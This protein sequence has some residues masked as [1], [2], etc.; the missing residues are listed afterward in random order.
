MHQGEFRMCQQMNSF[1]RVS[2]GGYVEVEDYGYLKNGYIMAGFSTNMSAV[3]PE[4]IRGSAVKI[5][6]D[7]DLYMIWVRE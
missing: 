4:F 1:E 6:S 2:D 3:T 5:D 7:M